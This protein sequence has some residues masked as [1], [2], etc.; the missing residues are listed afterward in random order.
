[1]LNAYLNYPNSAITVHRDPACAQIRS[2]RKQNQRSLKINLESM[3]EV[4]RDFIG[5]RYVFASTAE[6]NDMWLE[7]E[8]GDEQLSHEVLG[9]IRRTLAKKYSPFRGASIYQC[10]CAGE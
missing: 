4:L 9:F 1:M 5:A 6:N 3:G 10:G 7:I 8:C 2:H